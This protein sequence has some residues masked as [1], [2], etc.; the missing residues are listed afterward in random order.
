[1]R[2]KPKSANNQDEPSNLTE[3]QQGGLAKWLKFNNSD[4]TIK[5]EDGMAAQ[6]RPRTRS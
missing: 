3:H 6:P 1:M 5:Q 2:G 4:T